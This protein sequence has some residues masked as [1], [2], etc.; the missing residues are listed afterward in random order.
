MK[1]NKDGQLVEEGLVELS[2]TIPLSYIE[3]ASEDLVICHDEKIEA[4]FI[5]FSNY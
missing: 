5:Q 1:V 2:F 4:D 3:E